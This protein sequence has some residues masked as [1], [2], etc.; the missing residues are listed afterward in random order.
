MI[1]VD[2]L[3][4]LLKKN[5]CNFYTGVPDSVLKELSSYLESKNKKNH[6]I[7]TNE[8]SAVSIG[9]GHHLSTKKIPCIYMQNSG[10]SNA[11]NPIISIAHKKVYSIPL[12]L[13]IG[14][15]GSPKIN[16]EPQHNV[17]G[18]IT[19]NILKLL[20]IKYSIIRSNKDLGKFERQIK[21][22]KKNKTI[23]ACLIEKGTLKKNNN[24]RNHKDFYNLEKEVF[25]RNLLENIKKNTKIISS[26]GYNS[27]EIMYIRDKYKIKK[28]KDFYMVG[29]MGHT[30]S[31][32]LGYSLSSKNET[33]CIDG[34]GSFLMHLGSMKT[35]GSFADKNFKYILLNNNCHDSVG[36]QTTDID[37]NDLKKLSKSLG[38]Q[39]YSLIRN[40]HKL[41]TKIKN[42]LSQDSLNFL[43]V[44][45]RGSKISNLPR[46][47]NLIV[48]KNK[49][50]K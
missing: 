27:R 3:I 41:V 2:T 42:F 21:K 37:N 49:F 7:A 25:L 12:I 34:D 13:I 30:S 10:L 22:A 19:E 47:K 5:N 6:L 33:I 29:G 32:A 26:T 35:A 28:G 20:N 36:G 16:D 9:I 11:L 46:P 44:R 1:K 43:E 39:K 23:V 17:K 40:K 45:V 14:W 38:F 48:L 4:K 31:V 24:Y 15:R 50:I 18:K 8:G